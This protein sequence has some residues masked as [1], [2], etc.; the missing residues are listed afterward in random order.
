MGSILG[1]PYSGKLPSLYTTPIPASSG[2][3]NFCLRVSR[4]KFPPQIEKSAAMTKKRRQFVKSAKRHDLRNN[5]D[6]GFWPA[7]LFWSHSLLITQLRPSYRQHSATRTQAGRKCDSIC[8]RQLAYLMDAIQRPRS[9][10]WSV[11]LATHRFCACKLPSD[12]KP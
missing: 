11:C 6:H 3:R 2:G 4:P 10:L 5:E 7:R 12:L 9:S 8:S 1:S